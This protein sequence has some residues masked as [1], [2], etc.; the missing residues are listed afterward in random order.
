MLS[1][2][3]LVGQVSRVFGSYSQVLLIIDPTSAVDGQI[4]KTDSRGLVVGKV[5]SLGL[6][7]DLFIGAFEY[8]SQS[9]VIEEGTRVVTSGLDGIFPPGI[10]VGTVG[11]SKKKK[12]DVFQQAE[13][14][15]AVDFNKL[16]EV[17]VLK[18]EQ[19]E[20]R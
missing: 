5:M 1:P 10:L 20:A 15:P 4:E 2:D 18:Q 8:L 13:V 11:G 12:Y 17:L 7:R 9:T 3:G 16:R 6:K 19:G 14:I